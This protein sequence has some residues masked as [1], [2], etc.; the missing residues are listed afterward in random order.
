MRFHFKIFLLSIIFFY[1]N[2]SIIGQ[3]WKPAKVPIITKWGESLT[4][5]NVLQEYP[6]PQL[7]RKE[8]KNLNGMWN[9]VIRPKH[10]GLPE[11]F[12]GSILVPFPIESALSGVGKPVGKENILWYK[13]KFQLPVNWKNKLIILHFGAVDWESNIYVNKK[14]VGQHQ[15]GYDSFSFDITDYLIDSAEQEVIISVWCPQSYSITR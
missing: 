14:F 13:T 5:D 7:I 8:W 12:P 1:G 11:Q 4:P 10:L 15:G 2:F 6:R 3:D 9:F